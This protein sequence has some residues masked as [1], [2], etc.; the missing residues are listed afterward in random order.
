MDVLIPLLP[1]LAAVAAWLIGIAMIFIV[2]INRKPS[3]ATAWLLLIFIA[4]FLGLLIF[5]MI[6]YPRLNRRRRDQQRM[7]DQLVEEVVEE[8]SHDPRLQPYVD[9]PLEA[10]FVP[11]AHLTEQLGSMPA[12][13]GN[14]VTL[15]PEYD[16][17]I[18]RIAADIDQARVYV[19]IAFYIIA[20]DETS[21]WR[22]VLVETN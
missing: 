10:R 6:G 14:Q 3:S 21:E 2:P 1:A 16:E 13:A 22:L 12:F 9:P 20:L 7:M 18:R 4:P 15:V 11:L 5:L 17:I 19:H 8:I